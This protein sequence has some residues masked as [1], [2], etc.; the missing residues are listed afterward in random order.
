MYIITRKNNPRIKGL[1]EGTV[2]H[3]L[4]AFLDE[5]F[6]GGLGSDAIV[7]KIKFVHRVGY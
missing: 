6:T 2:G 7:V 5:L 4:T 1:K 3:N